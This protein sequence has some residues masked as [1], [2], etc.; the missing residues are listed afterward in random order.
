MDETIH[1]YIDALL[2]TDTHTLLVTKK[3]LWPSIIASLRWL[4][5]RP[6]SG[7]TLIQNGLGLLM[8]NN[9]AIAVEGFITDVL[10]EYLDTNEL[11]KSDRIKNI[12][13][14]SWKSKIKAYNKVF[15]NSLDKC[16]SYRSIELLFFLRNNTAHGLTHREKNTTEIATAKKSKIESIDK[17]YQKAREFFNEIGR[18][19][20][21]ELSS[22]IETLWGI[23]NCY[24]FLS[25]V[26]LF[27]HSVLENNKSEKFIGITSELNN[28]FKMTII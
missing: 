18:I 19:K 3:R 14:S 26:R 9:L 7:N 12:E 28:A 20:A 21:T 8:I 11:E 25:E 22:N 5:N 1:I 17:N 23:N 27:L 24:F 2:K 4:F 15:P 6:I 16:V 13:S 10:V